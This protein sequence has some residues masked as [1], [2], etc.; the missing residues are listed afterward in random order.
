MGLFL[1]P[2]VTCLRSFISPTISLTE[3]LLRCLS[4]DEPPREILSM[5]TGRDWVEKDY[6]TLKDDLDGG[7][8]Y[9][10]SDHSAI[11]LMFVQMIATSIRMFVSE[12]IRGLSG[13][14]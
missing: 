13:T 2:M 4:S 10:Q 1:L 5:Y 9:V 7:L 14:G 3:R 8:D 12:R 11:G 6:E